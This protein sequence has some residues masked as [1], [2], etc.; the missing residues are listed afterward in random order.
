ME[1][2]LKLPL[3]ACKKHDLER[4][5]RDGEHIGNFLLCLVLV[6]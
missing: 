5:L 6:L 4:D 2:E 1:A 3:R